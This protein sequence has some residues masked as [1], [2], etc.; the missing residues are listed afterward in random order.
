M[1]TKPKTIYLKECVH[2]FAH[3]LDLDALPTARQG[4]T[5]KEVMLFLEIKIIILWI[6]IIFLIR[7]VIK[8]LSQY[9]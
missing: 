5:K 4:L 1:I 6:I 2:L 7:D 8:R 9:L 3:F